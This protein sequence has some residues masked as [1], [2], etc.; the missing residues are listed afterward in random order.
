MSFESRKLVLSFK[1]GHSIVRTAILKDY[2]KM[3]GRQFLK[4]QDWKKGSDNTD[5]Q[6]NLD[7]R[8]I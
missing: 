1:K 2:N 6:K 5:G 3:Y 4:G 7:S 8:N